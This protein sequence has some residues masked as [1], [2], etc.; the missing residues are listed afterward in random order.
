M[1]APPGAV[2]SVGLCW[3][4]LGSVS[5]SWAQLVPVGLSWFQLGSVSPSWAMLVPVGLSW[6]QFGSVEPGWARLSSVEPLGLGRHHRMA[7]LCTHN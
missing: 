2:G 4:Q 3:S 5:P 1:D 7:S 6:S